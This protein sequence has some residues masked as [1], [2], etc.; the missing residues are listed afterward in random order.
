MAQKRPIKKSSTFNRP[1]VLLDLTSFKEDLKE[2]AEDLAEDAFERQEKR[3]A[4]NVHKEDVAKEAKRL[5]GDLPEIKFYLRAPGTQKGKTFLQLYRVLMDHWNQLDYDDPNKDPIWDVMTQLRNVRDESSEY[6][7]FEEAK[8]ETLKWAKNIFEDTKANGTFLVKL[9][10]NAIDRIKFWKGYP[11]R[12][13]PNFEKEYRENPIES[14][15]VTLGK[16]AYFLAFLDGKKLALVEDVLD[17]KDP[18]FFKDLDLESNYFDLVRELEKPG[19]TRKQ[20]KNLV[21]WTAR[22]RKDRRLYH[23]ATKVPPGIFLTT[24]P[25]RAFGIAHDLKGTEKVRDLYKIT[26]NEK[27]L[28]KTL[29]TKR[30]QDYQVIGAQRVPVVEIELWA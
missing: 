29:D 4:L 27:Y 28:R 3:R 25:E 22:P 26:I 14:F 18:E 15:M 20:G 1:K 2:V 12:I 10:Q 8:Q 7:S 19:S 16:D 24:D 11:V 5:L 13:E 23:K 9:V 21:L 30:L 6:Q 17:A